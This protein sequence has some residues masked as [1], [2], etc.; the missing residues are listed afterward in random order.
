MDKR[1]DAGIIRK[2]TGVDSDDIDIVLLDSVDST[3][4]YAKRIADGTIRLVAAE[5][6]SAGRGRLGRS[7]FS[8]DGKGIYMSLSL[9][10]TEEKDPVIYTVIAAVAAARVIERVSDKDAKI[11]WVNDVFCCGKKVCGI[12]CEG[13]I[14]AE[15]GKLDEVVVGVGMNLFCEK[16]DFPDEISDIAASVFP[17]NITR[18]EMIGMLSGEILGFLQMTDVNEIISEY[19]NRLFILGKKISFIRDGKEIEAVASDVNDKGNLIAFTDKGEEIL[20]SGE[21]TLGSGLYT[22]EEKS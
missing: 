7:F 19:K 22:D 5:Y 4:T 6:Q 3:N 20:S 14:N 17:K 13:I 21:I 10:V 1:L 15:T 8:P 2:A 9:P 12:L 18:S 11:K 16:E